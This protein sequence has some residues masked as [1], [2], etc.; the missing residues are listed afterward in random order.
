[1]V[2]ALVV[3]V[4]IAGAPGGSTTEPTP[5][6]ITAPTSRVV[7]SAGPGVR[8]LRP[9]L[10]P[11]AVAADGVCSSSHPRVVRVLQY[12]IHFAVSRSGAVDLA[13]IADEIET[14]RPDVVSLNEVDDGTLRTGRMDMPRYLAAASGLTAVYGPNLPWQGGVFGNA[15][16]TRYPVVA[17]SNQRLPG[18]PGLEPRGLLTTTLRV[19]GRTVSFS[20]THLSDGTSGRT[21]RGLQAQAI[22][23]ALRETADPAIVAGDLNS[24]PGDL[25]VRILRQHLLDSQVQGGTGPG[26]TI[27]E[28]A[29]QSRI[30]YV[31]YDDRWAVVP[32]STRALRSATSDHRAVFTELTLLPQHGC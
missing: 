11:D 7:P 19:G 1:V 24:D 29:P 26:L 2:L 3:V 17:S 23:D 16:L 13:D 32:G 10:R 5:S 25:P 18:A 31:L 15:I 28:A 14:V 12:N 27:P 4:A 21:S 30:D 6:V 22:A 9:P 8:R 20:S